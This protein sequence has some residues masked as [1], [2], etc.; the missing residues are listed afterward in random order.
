MGRLGASVAKLGAVAI[1]GASYAG[2]RLVS[3]Y[4]TATDQLTKAARRSGMTAQSFRE[5]QH[6]A[7]LA[8]VEGAEFATAMERLTRNLGDLRA[9]QG[10]L[11]TLLKRVSPE[12]LKALQNAKST[13]EAFALLADATASLSSEEERASLAAAA[14]GRSG[15]RM[16]LLL[17]QGTDAIEKQRE[18]V[19][20]YGG[21]LTEES[22]KQAE[23]FV[24]AQAR[25]QLALSGLKMAIGAEL[26]PVITPLIDA[27]RD[28]IVANKKWIATNLK[29]AVI[30]LVK[31]LKKLDLDKIKEDITGLIDAVKN[32]DWESVKIGIIAVLTPLKLLG[33]A[34]IVTGKALGTAAAMVVLSFQRAYEAL[35]H[36]WEAIVSGWEWAV[37]KVADGFTWLD[38]LV[39]SAWRGVVGAWEWMVGKLADGFT[40]LDEAWTNLWD[41]IVR[42]IES[43]VKRVMGAVDTIREGLRD[44]GYALGI[45]SAEERV[46][47]PVVS[48]PEEAARAH[49]AALAAARP[50]QAG[51]A[52]AGSAEV[53]VRFENAPPGLRVEQ[54][55]SNSPGLDVT[56]DVGRRMVGATP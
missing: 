4:A 52:L 31:W 18:E 24:D 17:Q 49:A 42:A 12:F 1:A 27:L 19:R 3:S 33:T 6:A 46:G 14:F 41:G 37:G 43:A 25:M 28:W 56:A 54:V 34:V 9:G 15:V 16:T 51:A 21:V 39:T 48:S 23:A 36:A 47:A 2:W 29:Q 45:V 13:E 22:A 5:L 11:Y 20:R 8:G 38:K 26:L 50:P 35:V 32:Y 30:G 40:W 55:A 53:R 7:N 10:A 44:I